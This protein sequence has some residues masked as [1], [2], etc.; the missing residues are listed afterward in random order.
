MCYVILTCSEP[1]LSHKQPSQIDKK[2]NMAH[3]SFNVKLE[4]IN[5]NPARFQNPQAQ[6]KNFRI[7]IKAQKIGK[8]V[9][10]FNILDVQSLIHQAR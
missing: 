2:K 8:Y 10:K 1:K 9:R 5:N 7:F 6:Q 4:E 3:H